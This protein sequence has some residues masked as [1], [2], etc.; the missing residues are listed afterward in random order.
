MTL[1]DTKL[2][3]VVIRQLGENIDLDVVLGESLRV[4]GRHAELFEPV[5]NLLHRGYQS[6]VV[7]CL[8][9]GPRQQRVYTENARYDRLGERFS[10]IAAANPAEAK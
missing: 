1:G 6:P 2:F 3:Q 5:R 8:G 4:L 10:S 9:F 7:A